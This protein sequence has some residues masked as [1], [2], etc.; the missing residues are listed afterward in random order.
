MLLSNNVQS[1]S[2]RLAQ[3]SPVSS[4]AQIPVFISASSHWRES[5][6]WS[7]RKRFS[8]CKDL[9]TKLNTEKNFLSNV[10]SV[11]SEKLVFKLDEGNDLRKSGKNDGPD[12]NFYVK[13]WWSRCY[14]KRRCRKAKYRDPEWAPPTQTLQQAILAAS[15]I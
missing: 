8:N 15:P 5:K 1:L 4:D 9:K 7:L 11:N 14:C 12:H 2:V 3:K 6:Y 10:S 13:P